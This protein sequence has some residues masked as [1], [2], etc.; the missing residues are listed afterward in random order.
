MIEEYLKMGKKS[1]WIV[2]PPNPIREVFEEFLIAES[3]ASLFSLVATILLTALLSSRF[4]QSTEFFLLDL[5]ISLAWSFALVG[6][7]FEKGAFF[8]Q[9]YFKVRKEFVGMDDQKYLK[10]ECY[11][12]IIRMGSLMMFWDI[13]IHDTT[14]VQLML[15]CQAQWPEVP[16]LIFFFMSFIVAAIIIGLLMYVI[17]EFLYLRFIWSL[18][19]FS[20]Q[21]PLLEIKRKILTIT[22]RFQG[23]KWWGRLRK[24]IL[25]SM[26]EVDFN[27]ERYFESRVRFKTMEQARKVFDHLAKKY[28]LGT[29]VQDPSQRQGFLVVPEKIIEGDYEDLYYDVKTFGFNHRVVRVRIRR[30]DSET[31]LKKNV[32][33]QVIVTKVSRLAKREISQHCYY[34]IKKSK[35]YHQIDSDVLIAL[36]QIDSRL[37]RKL[38]R[39]I[40][41]NETLEV[42]THRIA[43]QDPDKMLVSLDD[44]DAEPVIEIKAY[45][46]SVEIF[47]SAMAYAMNHEG[48][49]TTLGKDELV[50][51]NISSATGGKLIC[52]Y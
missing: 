31:G 40:A 41:G 14:Y 9:P 1:K 51:N 22:R 48:A 2:M 18:N 52:S 3:L 7:I 11:W 12:Q 21:L 45:P 38:R 6:P 30:R 15:Y 50:D 16:P 42:K 5:G 24:N 4:G 23:K 35:W 28:E 29:V 26:K 47:K 10:R 27:L 34:V 43:A 19:D 25:S 32:S 46:A 49:L 37:Y 13:A 36:D 17:M 33:V 44:F 8:I 20:D 39:I